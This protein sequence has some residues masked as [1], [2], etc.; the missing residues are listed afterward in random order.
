LS[1]RSILLGVS[2][3]CSEALDGRVFA[4][5]P[6]DL[7][8]FQSLKLRTQSFC[9]AKEPYPD[10]YE[11]YEFHYLP[12]W[13]GTGASQEYDNQSDRDKLQ[14]LSS[15]AQLGDCKPCNESLC[16]ELDSLE[17]QE[18]NSLVVP[19][20]ELPSTGNLRT[21]CDQLVMSLR[22]NA[23]DIVDLSWLCYLKH[24]DVELRTT[25][26]NSENLDRWLAE[27]EQGEDHAEEATHSR[28]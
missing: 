23:S 25:E 4:S 14:R 12:K 3:N 16:A 10:L 28:P 2:S 18:V 20:A 6:F 21:E 13:F 26:I 5:I 7:D 19:A 9:K 24:S 22:G 15:D 1:R 8:T 11:T 17:A 27:L